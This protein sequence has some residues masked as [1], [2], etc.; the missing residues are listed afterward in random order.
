MSDIDLSTLC[1]PQLRDLLDSTRQR[2]Q[3]AVAYLILQEM[4]DRRGDGSKRPPVG[5][6]RGGSSR[7]VAVDFS[8]PLEPPEDPLEPEATP[9]EADADAPLTLELDRARA[10]QP[11]PRKARRPRPEPTI[12]PPPPKPRRWPV[13]GFAAGIAVGVTVGFG[14]ARESLSQPETPAAAVFAAAPM[15]RTEQ[16]PP[17]AP[18]AAAAPA[19]TPVVATEATPEAAPVPEATPTTVLASAEPPAAA[20]PAASP[21]PAEQT[22]AAEPAA[23]ET[24]AAD[25]APKRRCKGAAT[26]ADRTIC[27]DPALQQLQAELRRA[28]A[29]ALDAHA[30]RALLRQHQLAWRDARNDVADPDQLTRLYEARIRKLNAATIA[31]RR[32]R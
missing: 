6:R 21:A 30:D 22:P 15:L 7:V 1:G 28:Y 12:G 2:G 10:R 32:E 24:A 27:D 9:A 23:T 5:A 4:A 19:P 8:D 25:P 3:A 26:P 14:I 17:P 11:K 16:L 31:A 13:I 20:Q 29:E 18:V